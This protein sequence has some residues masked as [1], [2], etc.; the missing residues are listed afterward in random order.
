MQLWACKKREFLEPRQT[1]AQNLFLEKAKFHFLQLQPQQLQEA[2]SNVSKSRNLSPLLT[3]ELYRNFYPAWH[4]SETKNLANGNV[5]M[6][7]PLV[8]KIEAHYPNSLFL[9]RRLRME[10][11]SNG[12]LITANIVEVYS[13][14]DFDQN[15]LEEIFTSLQEQVGTKLLVYNLGYELLTENTNH[16]RTGDTDGPS[17]CTFTIEYRDCEHNVLLS[18]SIDLGVAQ[19]SDCQSVTITI[20][21][22]CAS[23][24]PANPPSSPSTGESPSTGGG[25]PTW[26]GNLGTIGGGPWGGG[27]PVITPIFIG[28]YDPSYPSDPGFPPNTPPINPKDDWGW[29]PFVWQSG[30]EL[31][32]SLNA[33]Q[34]TKVKS[35]VESMIQNN[36]IV[37]PFLDYFRGLAGRHRKRL[38][39][40][41]ENLDGFTS[42]STSAEQGVITIKLNARKLYGKTTYGEIANTFVHELIH[43]FIHAIVMDTNDSN[44]ITSTQMSDAEIQNFLSTLMGIDKQFVYDYFFGEGKNYYNQAPMN[45]NSKTSAPHHN[46]IAD[47][48]LTTIAQAVMEYTGAPTSQLDSYIALAWWGLDQHDADRMPERFEVTSWANKP[49]NLK[50]QVKAKRKDLIETLPK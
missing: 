4:W 41:M 46:I 45:G 33:A 32:A 7:T 13:V 36:S 19:G 23:G 2:L 26:G 3:S 34:Y 14:Q 9:V 18:I 20:N 12:E 17:P 44:L 27:Y 5:L 8:R 16:Q 10:L 1:K 38:V 43:A 42:G 50:N 21:L 49:E 48:Y 28:G 40:K 22:S 24:G 37:Q 6:L 30:I 25:Y 47:L 39:I 31:D 35:V 29:L 15:Q 11:P